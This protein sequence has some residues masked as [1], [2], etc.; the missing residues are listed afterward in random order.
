MKRILFLIGFGVFAVH[1]FSQDAAELNDKLAVVSVAASG[2]SKS[3]I[4][5][6]PNPVS[7]ETFTIELQNLQKGKYSIF[8]YDEK[9]RK[10]LVKILNVEE[11][12]STELLQLPKKA[13]KGVYILQVISKTSR[14][15]KKMIVE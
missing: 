7:G 12:T 10:Y 4:Q 14:F 5:I 8:M 2:M 3:D 6:N 11:G 15:S 1:G 9:G 13:D